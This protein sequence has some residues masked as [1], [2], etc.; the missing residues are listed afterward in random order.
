MSFPMKLISAA[1][2]SLCS[3]SSFAFDNTDLVTKVEWSDYDSVVNMGSHE[4]TGLVVAGHFILTTR[5]CIGKK[6][7]LLATAHSERYRNYLEFDNEYLVPLLYARNS[8]AVE[9]KTP[10]DNEKNPALAPI[11]EYGYEVTIEH[12]LWRI[13]N[14]AKVTSIYP[15]RRE[16]IYPNQKFR[17]YSFRNGTNQFSY[18]DTLLRKE[19]IGYEMDGTEFVDI[20]YPTFFNGESMGV[21]PNIKDAASNNPYGPGDS[22]SPLMDEQG[23]VAGI[24]YGINAGNTSVV[25]SDSYRDF[26]LDTINGWYAPTLAFTKNGSVEVKIQSLLDDRAASAPNV[27]LTGNYGELIKFDKPGFSV[28]PNSFKCHANEAPENRANDPMDGSNVKPYDVCTFAVNGVDGVVAKMTINNPNGGEP[29]IMMINEQPPKDEISPDPQP[30][31]DS[32][33]SGG[34]G[35]SMGFLTLLGLVGLGLRRRIR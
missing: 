7:T 29:A 17:G 3:I 31:P 10:E 11:E 33:K 5:H 18:L 4:C 6:D 15:I 26:Y 24:W 21:Y 30:Q 13:K 25:S 32:G 27:D 16:P 28:E 12:S 20:T 1:T 19:E 8:H 22:G 35:G 34:S 23:N 9:N 2:L 14:N